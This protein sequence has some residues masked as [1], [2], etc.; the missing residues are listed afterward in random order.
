MFSRE[1]SSDVTDDDSSSTS[2]SFVVGGVVQPP[3]FSSCSESPTST[4]SFNSTSHKRPLD[5]KPEFVN[6]ACGHAACDKCR[7]QFPCLICMKN[8][9]SKTSSLIE[10]LGQVLNR[11][12]SCKVIIF[13]QW[14]MYLDILA[15]LLTSLGYGY[16]RYDGQIVSIGTRQDIVYQFQTGSERILLTSLMAG[17]LG[18][19]LAVANVVFFADPW[20]N[21]AVEE[22]A[23]HRVHRIGQT[24]PVQVYRMITNF[25][26]EASVLRIQRAKKARADFFVD[27]ILDP[28]DP[29]MKNEGVLD[30]QDVE[31]LVDFIRHKKVC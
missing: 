1:S 2:S 27:G 21:P 5:S 29:E 11:D 22:Q 13:S 12:P 17:G 25:S 18:L 31:C 4:G 14:T 16:L 26:I 30:S 19:N 8:A 10:K 28:E 20:W 9:S 6:Y 3:N 7:A 15:E 23:E 24:K